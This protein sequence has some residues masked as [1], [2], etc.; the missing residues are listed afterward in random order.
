MVTG[1]HL[2][3]FLEKEYVQSYASQL[4]CQV[5]NPNSGVRHGGKHCTPD[6]SSPALFARF[7]VVAVVFV[8][9]L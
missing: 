8:F 4:L 5:W 6:P 9:V 1:S 7:F 3:T 2:S